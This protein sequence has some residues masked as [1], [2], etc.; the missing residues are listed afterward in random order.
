M[1]LDVDGKQKF[2]GRKD[3]QYKGNSQ[4]INSAT[5]SQ[6]QVVITH[7]DHTHSSDPR[8]TPWT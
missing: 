1:Q 6:K 3:N 7:H 8:N 5:S 2:N 4:D